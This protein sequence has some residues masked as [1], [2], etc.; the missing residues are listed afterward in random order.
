M[1]VSSQARICGPADLDTVVGILVGAF[2]D[3]PTW[4]RVFPDEVRRP[5]HLRALWG[6][7]VAG[8]LRYPATWLASGAA[9]TA[10]WIPPG[11]TELSEEQEVELELA[12]IE[13]L[14]SGADQV[15]GVLDAFEEAH[16]RHE[17]HFYLTLLGTDVARRGRGVG[18]ALLERSLQQVDAVNAPAY[19]EASNPAN[20]AL[21]ARYGF[22]VFDSF[23]LPDGGGR[24]TTMWRAPRYG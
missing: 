13:L 21:Y 22:E 5:A 7:F 24:V 15:M 3:D 11:G 18:L 23:A 1:Q 19:L 20:V 8:A 17:P 6:S 14:A 16:P 10:V 9:A 12:L 2:H 4:S